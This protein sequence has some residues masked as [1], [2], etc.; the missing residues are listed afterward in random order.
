MSLPKL[1]SKFLAL[2]LSLEQVVDRVTVIPA[3]RL[4][5]ENEIATLVNNTVAD[6]AIFKQKMRPVSFVDYM[7][8]AVS[9][10]RLLVP[11]M[12]IKNGSIKYSAPD[13]DQVVAA[14]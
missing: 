5:M 2:G 10:D 7:G 8:A 4:G 13:F 3:R 14:G 9:G 11:Q 12:T 6:V 1:M